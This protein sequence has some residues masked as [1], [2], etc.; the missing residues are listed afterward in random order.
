M[1][2]GL[3]AI[4]TL[5][6]FREEH[7]RWVESGDYA[8]DLQRTPKLIE[9]PFYPDKMPLDKDN[10]LL[11]IG[12]GKRSLGEVTHFHGRV[13]DLRGEPLKGMTVEIWQ[14]DHHGVYIHSGSEG[15]EKRDPLFQ[16]FGKFETSSTGVYTFRTIK[17]VPYPGRTPHIHIKVKK[18]DRELLCTQCHV[19]D[20]PMLERDGVYRSISDKKLRELVVA[21]FEPNPKSKAGELEARFDIV[22][23]A[24]PEA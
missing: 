11:M 16:G 2:T 14:V 9:G 18:G 3:V 22:L 1:A 7:L 17:P 6:V 20:H 21:K 19:A 12:E 10:D 5:S 23:G 4:P 8:D 15:S 24:T 13:M